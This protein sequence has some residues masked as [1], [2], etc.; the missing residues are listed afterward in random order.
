MRGLFF[1]ALVLASFALAPI[2]ATA[3]APLPPEQ[4]YGEIADPSVWPFSAIG[5]VNRTTRSDERGFCTGTL[6]APNL[7][8]TA[9]HCLYQDEGVRSVVHFVTAVANGVPAEHAIA[10]RVVISPQYVPH[11]PFRVETVQNDWGLIVLNQALATKPV[12]VRSLTLA[13]VEKAGPFMHVGYGKDRPFLPSVVR[14]CWVGGLDEQTLMYRCLTNSGFSGAP[15][16]AQI[17][18]TYAVVGIGSGSNHEMR[19][20]YA[21]SATQFEKAVAELLKPE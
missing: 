17:G 18:G 5:R 15:I 12:P 19:Q 7:V 8:L 1:A 3:Q 9:A 4:H 13:Q 20:G 16:L 2:V 21:C 14:D 6:V 10:K 11:Q